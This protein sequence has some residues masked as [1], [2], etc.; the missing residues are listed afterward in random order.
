M[1]TLR[2]GGE[3]FGTADGSVKTGGTG[4]TSGTSGT[5][6]PWIIG[7]LT[8]D[9][10]MVEFRSRRRIFTGE[11][12][13]GGPAAVRPPRAATDPRVVCAVRTMALAAVTAKLPI[14]Y[15]GR[16]RG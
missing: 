13:R 10:S 5:G 11:A 4:G 7:P 15:S 12:L 3:I 2:G 1:V 8:T 6:V 14:C 16:G 9:E